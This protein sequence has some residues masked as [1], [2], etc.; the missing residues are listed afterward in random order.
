MLKKHGFIAAGILGLCMGTAHAVDLNTDAL[1]KMQ[2]EGD[3]IIAQE[4]GF[5][6]LRLANGNCLTAGGKPGQAGANVVVQKC[7]DKA[8]LQKWSF[9][10]QGRL[11]SH[12]GTCVGTAGNATKP[13]T[14]AVLQNCAGN[15]QQKWALDKQGRVAG[16]SGLCLQANGGNVVAAACS[17]AAN[18]KWQ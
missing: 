16:R 5:Q 8:N 4:K 10:D 9:D 6:M 3:K 15:P 14:N 13:G 17:G 11:V 18:Q 12:G 1:K 7:N 2:E